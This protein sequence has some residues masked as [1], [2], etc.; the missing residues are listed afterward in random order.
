[1]A[2]VV[3]HRCY[4]DIQAEQIRELLESNGIGCQI[5][6]DV[7]HSVFPLT[8]DGLGEVRIAVLEED[9]VRAKELIDEFLDVPDLSFNQSDTDV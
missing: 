3:I 8:L 7:P 6:S 2:S 9:A 1:M 5:A 4:D